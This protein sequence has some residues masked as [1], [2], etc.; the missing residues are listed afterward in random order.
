MEN[1]MGSIESHK[2][3]EPMMMTTYIY[4]QRTPTTYCSV[5]YYLLCTDYRVYGI[6]VARSTTHHTQYK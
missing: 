4:K 3:I 1:R 6:H 5:I 2:L